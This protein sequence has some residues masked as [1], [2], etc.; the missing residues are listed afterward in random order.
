[1]FGG[2]LGGPVIKNKT[3]FFLSYEGLRLRQPA[4]QQ[5]VVPDAASRQQAPA[6]MQPYLNAYPIANG[7]ALGPGIAQFNASYSNPSTLNAGSIRLDHALNS[8]VTLFARYNDSPSSLDQRSPVLAGPVLSMTQS[9]L[10]SVQTGTIG[11]T[12]LI[13]PG[14]SDEVRANYS[15][16]EV[17]SRFHLDNFGGAAP[18]P[19]SL[20]F[21][22][23]NSS[24]TS[25]F[26]FY[27]PGVG[28]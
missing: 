23:G 5:S 9:L 10:S 13:T 4:T 7:P 19:D 14:I 24:E 1:D 22:P 6:A 2:V 15:N 25:E 17:S 27:I 28:A 21:P 3:F 16:Q 11:A 8:K 12:A 26:V 18:L 20:L